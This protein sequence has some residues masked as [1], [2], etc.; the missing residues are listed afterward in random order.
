VSAELGGLLAAIDTEANGFTLCE[1]ARGIGLSGA[2]SGSVSAY[3]VLSGTLCLHLSTGEKLRARPGEMV[4]IPAKV[5]PVIAAQKLL[6]TRLISGSSSVKPRNGILVADV[7]RGRNPA[8]RV[9]AARIAG[10]NAATLAEPSVIAI[11]NDLRGQQALDLLREEIEGPLSGSNALAVTLM[12]ACVI[13]ALRLA[14]AV[15]SGSLSGA[16]RSRHMAI[17]RA[18]AVIMARPGDA[19]CIDTLAQLAGMS[20]S[21]FVRHFTRMMQAKPMEFVQRVRLN[22][23]GTILRM[24]DLPVKTVAATVGFASRSHFSRAFRDF[25]GQ[26]PSDFR[27]HGPSDIA[28]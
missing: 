4:F 24:T 18:I 5:S 21:T 12:R 17:Q 28:I 7:T 25:H 3:L 1:V 10:T 9:A 8:V 13:V 11:G 23:A 15:Q 14:S 20:R 2:S 19:H 6:P 27:Q 16:D 26:D 22:E